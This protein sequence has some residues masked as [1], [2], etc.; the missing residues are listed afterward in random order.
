MGRT[1]LPTPLC[2]YWLVK[3]QGYLCLVL[4]YAF[5]HNLLEAYDGLLTSR[6]LWLFEGLSNIPV[7]CYWTD[8]YWLFVYLTQRQD[9]VS[10]IRLLTVHVR[11]ACVLEKCGYVIKKCNLSVFRD[12]KLP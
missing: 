4:Q 8:T 7:C 9:S 12:Q 2:A 10:C 6:N 1:V 5:L 3:G 11:Y